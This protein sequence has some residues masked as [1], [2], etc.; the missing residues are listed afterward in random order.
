MSIEEIVEDLRAIEAYGELPISSYEAGNY[1]DEIEA[2]LA[3]N[4]KLKEGQIDAE[5]VV[6][7]K[8]CVCSL[9]TNDGA[10]KCTH[11]QWSDCIFGVYGEDFCSYGERKGE[12]S[13]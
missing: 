4:A 13:E 2:L 5:P 11:P 1:A 3:E 7:C 8:D 9:P 10:Y 12:V 6:R